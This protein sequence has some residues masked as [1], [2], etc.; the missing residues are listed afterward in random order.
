MEINIPLGKNWSLE[1]GLTCD[2]LDLITERG[3]NFDLAL[4]GSDFGWY[5]GDHYRYVGLALALVGFRLWLSVT[6]E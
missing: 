4:V 2:W 1:V 3:R 6:G 5:W